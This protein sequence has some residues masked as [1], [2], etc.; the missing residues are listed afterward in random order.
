MNSAAKTII[1]TIGVL[2]GIGIVGSFFSTPYSDTTNEPMVSERNA[3][4]QTF[5]DACDTSGTLTKECTCAANKVIDTY[6]NEQ[7]S[8]ILR[9]REATGNVPQSFIDII[10]SCMEVGAV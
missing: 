3:K 10:K 8:A 1:I 2:I 6:T 5:V 7:M 9:E 4:I